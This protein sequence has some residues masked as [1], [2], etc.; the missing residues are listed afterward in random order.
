MWKFLII[1]FLVIPFG[2]S[3]AQQTEVKEKLPIQTRIPPKDSIRQNVSSLK[4][5]FLLY[6]PVNSMRYNADFNS[7]QSSGTFVSRYNTMSRDFLSPLYS[8]YLEEQSKSPYMY[9]LGVAQGAA[10]GYLLY[11]HIS[12]Y[13]VWDNKNKK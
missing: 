9:I 12:K 4:Q 7:F 8:K 5:D 10:A 6:N 13:G 2:W 3:V 11:E 1:P